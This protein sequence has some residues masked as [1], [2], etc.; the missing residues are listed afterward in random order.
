[1]FQLGSVR[2]ITERFVDFRTA[3][4]NKKFGSG[5]S[6]IASARLMLKLFRAFR[7]LRGIFIL[8]RANLLSQLN[9]ETPS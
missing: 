6:V 3:T 7:V 8:L 4:S 2:L 9:K 5:E 1:M